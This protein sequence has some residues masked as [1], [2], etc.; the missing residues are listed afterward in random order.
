MSEG[1]PFPEAIHTEGPGDFTGEENYF[2]D[3]QVEVQ[4]VLSWDVVEPV[5]D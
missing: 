1:V 5:E 2:Y 4:W 3:G